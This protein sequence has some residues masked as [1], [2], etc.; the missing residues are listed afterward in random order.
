MNIVTRTFACIGLAAVCGS[1][2]VQ[3]RAEQL[4]VPFSDPTRPGT[5]HIA[6]VM[7]NI[8]V[9]GREAKD[10]LIETS[11][12]DDSWNNGNGRATGLRQLPQQ[13][14]FSV[15]ERNNQMEV[16]TPNPNRRVDF[17]IQVPARTHLELSTV[18]GGF[19]QVDGVE[20]E[21]EIS[22]VNGTITLTN[23]AGS[24]VAHTVNGKISATLTRV[25]PQK[26]MAFTSLNGAVD[27]NLPADI[28]ANLKLRTDNGS[29]FTDYDLNL[30]PQPTSAVIEDTR[31]PD[32][33]YRIEVNKVIYGAV[34]GGG[35]EIEMRTF[36]GSI[37]V[38]KNK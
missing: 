27:I 7:G 19:I 10:V 28:K 36:N 30:L 2:T 3:V 26:P 20:G 23:V 24:V 15:E 11:G 29:V 12:R 6:I 31:R 34:N 1:A 33:R 18:N 16:G 8:V 21:L 22:N 35:P 17:D 37:Y 13:P 25:A 14:S 32:G 9:K 5:L 38:R 4:T